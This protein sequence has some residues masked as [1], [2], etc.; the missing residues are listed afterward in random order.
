[1]GCTARTGTSHSSKHIQTQGQQLDVSLRFA[2]PLLG[3]AA[4]HTR[5]QKSLGH[6]LCVCN[7]P[8][9]YTLWGCSLI[10]RLP[11][12]FALLPVNSLSS[13]VMNGVVR[14]VADV[15]EKVAIEINRQ[16]SWINQTSG[17]KDKGTNYC[18]RAGRESKQL[19]QGGGWFSPGFRFVL[20][21]LHDVYY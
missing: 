12:R 2:S 1:M 4:T 10:Q 7:A 20:G 11:L 21:I 18:V 16:L 13:R 9:H 5:T 15:R 19:T 14:S 8:T 3:N 6:I 17:P